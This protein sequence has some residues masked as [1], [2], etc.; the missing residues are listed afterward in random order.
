MNCSALFHIFTLLPVF[1]IVRL[2]ESNEVY[3]LYFKWLKEIWFI[4][5]CAN[6]FGDYA[7]TFEHSNTESWLWFAC[8]EIFAFIAP[9]H[10]VGLKSLFCLLHCR[11]IL[12]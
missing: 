12:L 1:S 5:F 2:S 3:Y 8:D 11:Y 4:I 7:V 10:V 9:L 6:K